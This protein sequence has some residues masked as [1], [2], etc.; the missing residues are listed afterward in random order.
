MEYNKRDTF[1]TEAKIESEMIKRAHTDVVGYHK[2]QMAVTLMDM[3]IHKY[4]NNVFLKYRFI[5]EDITPDKLKY[6]GEYFEGISHKRIRA[7][8]EVFDGE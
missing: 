6:N 4:T 7:I 1:F 5:E 8:L 3:A 2:R